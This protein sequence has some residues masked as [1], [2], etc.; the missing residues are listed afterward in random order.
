MVG[1]GSGIEPWHTRRNYRQ[2]N[3]KIYTIILERG[4]KEEYQEKE[5]LYIKTE[6][7]KEIN[8]GEGMERKGRARKGKGRKGRSRKEN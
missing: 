2:T 3:C 7:E 1:C 4:R 8:M 6:K 5:K